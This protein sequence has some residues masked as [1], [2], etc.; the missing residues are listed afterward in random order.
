[1]VLKNPM[2]K[3]DYYEVL[4]VARD[5]DERELKS[6]Y[7]QLAR[8]YHPDLNPGN[9]DAEAQFKLASEAY[10]VL[11]DA[12]RRRT[13]DRF[14]HEGLD[15]QSYG[16]GAGF[17]SVEDIL[18]QFDVFDE[19]LNFSAEQR[20]K[21]DGSPRKGKDLR[22]KLV[23][24][25]EEALRGTSRTFEI[26]RKEPCFVCD[27]TGA[28]P[29]TE[30]RECPHCEGSGQI[31]QQQVFFTISVDCPECHGLGR[32]FEEPCFECEGAGELVEHRTLNIRIPAGVDNGTRLRVRGEGGIGHHGGERGD[33]IVTLE[34]T[35]SEH[36]ERD[37]LDIHY[38]AP[39]SFIQAALG[40][41]L[42]IPTLDEPLTVTIPPGTQFG[43]KLELSG[44]G[45]THVNKKRTG[46]LVVHFVVLT[47]T[48]LSPEAHA[49]LT[50]LAEVTGT[51]LEDAAPIP[52]HPRVA[53]RAA[54]EQ[55][56]DED[57]EFAD[58]PALSSL[59][60]MLRQAEDALDD[61]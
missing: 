6:A 44:R 33:V 29:D 28:E 50:Q 22:H 30:V 19:V 8:K 54:D 52:N 48:E 47:P 38:R 45:I 31:S 40:G 25:F 3:R 59:E 57:D 56:D 18:S 12:K 53:A 35:P 27:G 21:R 49:L 14:G 20:R 46:T 5:A 41:T 9:A 7:R 15:S 23:I 42:V 13:Y 26:T 58:D 55:L 51:R 32:L 36:F 1:M 61:Y 4:G 11:N 24:S 60:Q 34:V 16:V 37:G 10:E 2:S 17:E 39:I 43:D